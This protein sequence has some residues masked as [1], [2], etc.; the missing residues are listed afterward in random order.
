MKKTTYLHI[1]DTYASDL[2]SKT[3]FDYNDHANFYAY[4][5]VTWYI[6]NF[7]TNKKY[8]ELGERGDWVSSIVSIGEE[9]LCICFLNAMNGE[10]VRQMVLPFVLFEKVRIIDSINESTI[11]IK[12]NSSDVVKIKIPKFAKKTS[13]KHQNGMRLKICDGIQNMK[14]RRN[15]NK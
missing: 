5:Y 2:A 9:T 13:L 3:L 7:I 15:R 1:T 10:P 6:P 11:I 12:F 4:S 14:R 8:E